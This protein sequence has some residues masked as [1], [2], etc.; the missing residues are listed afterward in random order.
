MIALLAV[1]AE[2]TGETAAEPAGLAHLREWIRPLRATTNGHLDD[3][4]VNRSRRAAG[5]VDAL[6]R[7]IDALDD[8]RQQPPCPIRL[9][10][11][12][13]EDHVDHIRHDA[14][15]NRQRAVV[16]RAV[17]TRAPS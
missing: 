1:P 2:R 11:R 10:P 8:G 16:T 12:R 14:S 15:C 6:F 7:A 17:L 4:F 3:L 13:R 9:P 5:V